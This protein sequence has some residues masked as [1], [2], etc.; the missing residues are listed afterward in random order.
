MLA[1][2]LLLSSIY[3]KSQSMKEVVIL[4]QLEVK[5]EHE[6]KVRALLSEYV[7]QALGSK[8]NIMVEAYYEEGIPVLSSLLFRQGCTG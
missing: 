8:N 2:S 6:S 7:Q 5:K 4:T 3:V 1:M